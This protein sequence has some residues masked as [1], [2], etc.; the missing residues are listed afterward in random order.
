MNE[1]FAG[2]LLRMAERIMVVGIAG[3][4]IYFGFRL[5]MAVPHQQ[6]SDG[7][8]ELPGVSL[9]LSKAGPGLFFALFGSFVLYAVVQANIQLGENGFVGGTPT[10]APPQAGMVAGPVAS[11]EERAAAR[12]SIQTL[13]CL[14]TAA[15]SAD[16][17]LRVAD[18]EIAIHDAKVALVRSVWD[19]D[20]WGDTAAFRLWA[21][22]G[23]G[24]VPTDLESF[25][26]AELPECI[27]R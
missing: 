23:E 3:V 9:T 1:V 2:L 10:A 27:T 14:Q 8:L 13:N 25:F 15:S 24:S 17:P 7:K 5:F 16:G 20:A 6:R 26:R 19:Y 12:R 4:T 11:A 18:V 21:G 22:T